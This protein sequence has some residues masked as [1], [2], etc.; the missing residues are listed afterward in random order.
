MC[1]AEESIYLSVSS[2]LYCG[3]EKRTKF[4][5]RLSNFGS[6]IFLSQNVQNLR[7]NFIKSNFTRSARNF[8]KVSHEKRKFVTSGFPYSDQFFPFSLSLVTNGKHKLNFYVGGGVCCPMPLEIAGE[9]PASD[10][11]FSGVYLTS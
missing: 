9:P 10:A 3:K 4:H 2:F 1:T 11:P 5:I 8:A 6:G 7:R